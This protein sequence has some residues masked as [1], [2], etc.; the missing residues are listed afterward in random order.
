M[1]LIYFNKLNE[2]LPDLEAFNSR[3]VLRLNSQE[4]LEFSTYDDRLQKYD[5]VL[6][7]RDTRWYE[8]TVQEI[9]TLHDENGVIY[10]AWAES[11]LVSDLK[12]KVFED[13]RF[14]NKSA[15][16]VLQT[17]VDGTNWKVGTVADADLRTLNF[18]HINAYKALSSLLNTYNLE[19]E[20]KIQVIGPSVSERTVSLVQ[21]TGEKTGR[22]FEFGHDLIEVNRTVETDDVITALYGFGK[23][24]QKFDE[25]GNPTGGYGRR[26]DFK[27][28]NGGK[29]YVADE[30]ARAN[31]GVL[32]NGELKHRYGIVIY[33]DIEDRSELLEATRKDLKKL[34]KPKVS[35]KA[36]VIDLKQYGLD[37]AG[38][39]LG[40]EVVI[41]DRVLNLS[42]RSRLLEI[43]ITDANTNLTLGNLAPNLSSRTNNIESQISEVNDKVEATN[44]YVATIGDLNLDE[45][46]EK[47]QEV[48]ENFFSGLSYL[49]FSPETGLL[50]F[51]APDEANATEAIQM[52]QGKIRI[53]NSKDWQGNWNWTTYMDG[54]GMLADTIGGKQ[55]K[56][57]SVGTD[58]LEAGV[59]NTKNIFIG[60]D[61]QKTLDQKIAA[62]DETDQAN[63]SSLKDETE[64]ALNEYQDAVLAQAK[65]EASAYAD[66][67]LTLSEQQALIDARRRLEEAKEYADEHNQKLESELIDMIG[68]VDMR[69]HIQTD[70]VTG[71][72]LI[73]K[74]DSGVQMRLTNDRLSI[75]MG[76]EEVAYFGNQQLYITEAVVRRFMLGDDW[77]I[78]VS[79]DKNLNIT[80]IGGS[81]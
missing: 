21:Q 43:E 52:Y 69:T 12:A 63:Y 29:P 7:N 34:S 32:V 55:I 22:R 71:D 57:H 58:H 31:Y 72:L 53:A 16:T 48:N 36:S 67:V 75:E 9:E 78:Q 25:E 50:S 65:A 14:Q 41:I 1:K 62:L 49:K 24:E 35:Y 5:K 45:I 33:Q 56:A 6:V 10:Q 15:R 70:P 54:H 23:G 61:E 8:F 40:D 17:I 66:N 30:E 59:L 13:R 79:P 44:N 20:T 3:M 46:T 28:L 18:Y 4:T 38:I 68:Q 73:G 39:G 27:D 19:I 47:I 2:R 37:F 77:E 11:S 42:L 76:G 64:Q 51:N 26:I 80:W 60:D 74:P 81:E